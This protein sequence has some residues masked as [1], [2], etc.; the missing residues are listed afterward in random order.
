MSSAIGVIDTSRFSIPVTR[1]SSYQLSLD[2]QHA[3]KI[4]IRQYFFYYLYIYSQKIDFEIHEKCPLSKNL[5]EMAM[6]FFF[7]SG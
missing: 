2:A 4:N 3:E 6:F 1:K 7:F 5:H